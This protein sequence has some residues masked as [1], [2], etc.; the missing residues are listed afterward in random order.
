MLTQ[1]IGIFFGMAALR[2]I[3]WIRKWEP[4]P[5]TRRPRTVEFE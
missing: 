3:W 5:E 4:R 1:I 2:F